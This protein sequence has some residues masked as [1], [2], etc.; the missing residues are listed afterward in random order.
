MEPERIWNRSSAAYEGEPGL[1]H[2]GHAT[3]TA[4]EVAALVAEQYATRLAALISRRPDRDLR[5]TENAK[6]R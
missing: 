2:Y 5:F 6:S 3:H 1:Q 4:A